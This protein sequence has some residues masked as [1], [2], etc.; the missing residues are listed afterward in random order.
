M[1]DTRVFNNRPPPINDEETYHTETTTGHSVTA[2][3]RPLQALELRQKVT[4]QIVQIVLSGIWNGSAGCTSFVQL[5]CSP[6]C[7]DTW[8]FMKQTCQED[9][10]NELSIP[11]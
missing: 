4:E 6:H 2:P 7:V 8:T 10:R 11:G 1:M 5:H 9:T 3:L